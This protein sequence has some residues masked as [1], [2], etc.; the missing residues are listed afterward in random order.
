M[1]KIYILIVKKNFNKGD[2]WNSIPYT[3]LF[4]IDKESQQI[5]GMD[6]PTKEGIEK[7]I[8]LILK[9]NKISRKEVHIKIE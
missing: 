5:D 9:R 3:R 6:F 7:H 8:K 1:T 4:L 2:N